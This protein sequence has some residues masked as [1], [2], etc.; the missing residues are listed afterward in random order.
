VLSFVRGV[1]GKHSTVDITDLLRR[2]V[3]ALSDSMPGT[4]QIKSSIPD[5]P[6]VI[7]GDPTQLRQVLVN[8]VMNARDAMP[9]GGC[10]SITQDIAHIDETASQ[11]ILNA[12]GSFVRWS[13]NDS[14]IG[15]R[16]ENLEKIFD[17]FYTTKDIGKGTGLGLSIV[18][19]IVKGHKGFI[20]VEST[21]GKG[22]TFRVHLPV[23]KE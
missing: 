5:T 17:P 23:G 4:I 21:E 8:L 2:A 11:K 3:Y 22:T 7:H 16:Q 9:E 19:G 6:V 1:E 15:I 14:G 13:I 20:T 10:I 18:T 12:A